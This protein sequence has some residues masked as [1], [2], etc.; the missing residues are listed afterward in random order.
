M[1]ILATVSDL[2]KRMM[3]RRDVPAFVL[4]QSKT[5]YK[6]FAC[7]GKESR[8]IPGG[9]ENLPQKKWGDFGTSAH[10]GDDVVMVARY[11]VGTC[12]RGDNKTFR[13]KAGN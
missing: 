11:R 8:R 6:L 13:K 7:S 12:R 4:D 10:D 9:S 5:N 1:V 3:F 2:I